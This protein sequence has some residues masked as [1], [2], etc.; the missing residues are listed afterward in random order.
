MANKKENDTGD[1]YLETENPL[2]LLA[3]ENGALRALMQNIVFDFSQDDEVSKVVLDGSLARLSAFKNHYRKID[4]VLLYFLHDEKKADEFRE[5][6]K[7]V[8]DTYDE[9]MKDVSDVFGHKKEWIQLLDM[10][11][12]NIIH[13]NHFLLPRLEMTLNDFDLQTIWIAFLGYPGCLIS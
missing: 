13:E 12:K 8:S 9:L 4:E 7:S 11:E 3:E 6:E 1:N 10:M 2:L 5:E